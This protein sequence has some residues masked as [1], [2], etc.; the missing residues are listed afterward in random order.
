MNS[1]RQTS[2]HSMSLTPESGSVEKRYNILDTYPFSPSCPVSATLTTSSE[3]SP[4]YRD[5]RFGVRIAVRPPW[6]HWRGCYLSVFGVFVPSSTQLHAFRFRI[7]SV[8][9]PPREAAEVLEGA[10][11]D[12][13]S[14]RGK[15]II[16][17]IVVRED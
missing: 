17:N 14:L 8:P 13:P 2:F 4:D 11:H 6:L 16:I 5:P 1:M 9:E 3:V 15:L 7:P 10:I 12:S